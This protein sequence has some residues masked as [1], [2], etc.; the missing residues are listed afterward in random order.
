MRRSGRLS[1]VIPIIL[2]LTLLMPGC[3]SGNAAVQLAREGWN[4]VGSSATEGFDGYGGILICEYTSKSRLYPGADLDY[5]SLYDD[6][7]SSGT[8]IIYMTDASGFDELYAVFYSS[9]GYLYETF[10]YA[11]WHDLYEYYYAIGSRGVAYTKEL[12]MAVIFLC[13][14]N[15][16]SGMYNH[17]RS[18]ADK[19]GN[20]PGELEANQWYLFSDRQEKAIAGGTSSLGGGSSSGKSSSGFNFDNLFSLGI[21]T[22][23]LGGT[24]FMI[25]ALLTLVV[26]FVV[27]YFI[28]KKFEDVALEKGYQPAS[29]HAFA[30]CFW[31]GIPGM[32]YILALPNKRALK[33]QEDLLKELKERPAPV[34][35][36]NT[37]APAPAAPAPASANSAPAADPTPAS[38]NSAPAQPEPEPA[39]DEELPDL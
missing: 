23:L 27:Q 20:V 15:Y 5:V 16:I 26:Y 9:S 35:T 38:V 18:V 13:N 3:S 36:V 4:E 7:P 39:E 21:I 32:L 12:T 28:A 11:E 25:F 29:I 30:I 33:V 37:P 17:A 22:S 6:I 34:I 10:D 31:L 8:A 1:A 24:T 2:I 14:C 19:K